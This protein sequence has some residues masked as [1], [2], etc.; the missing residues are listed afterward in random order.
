MISL[1][2][3][4]LEKHILGDSDYAKRARDEIKKLNEPHAKKLIRCVLITGE[5]GAGKNHLARVLAAH[6]RLIE[7]QSFYKALEIPTLEALNIETFDE[8]NL[9]SLSDDLIQSELFGHKARSFSGADGKK[10][11]IGLLSS[12]KSPSFSDILL[13]EIG[14]ASPEF[15]ANLLQVIDTGCFRPVG[16]EP[17]DSESTTA[18]FIFATN[19]NLEEKVREGT[20]REDLFHRL[21]EVQI[22]VPPLRSYASHI[23]ELLCTLLSEQIKDLGMHYPSEA[24]TELTSEELSW[25]KEFQWPGNIR[26]LRT[27]VKRW[28]FEAGKKQLFDLIE[29]PLEKKSHK[30]LEDDFH[31]KDFKSIDK[32]LKHYSTLAMK[33]LGEWV[34]EYEID[35]NKLQ[36]MFSRATLKNIKNK[37]NVYKKKP[38]DQS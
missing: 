37:I 25:A 29:V 26:A 19:H 17:G 11:K 31:E 22:E 24:R 3:Q 34:E 38:E 16:A 10:D 35:A 33:E 8:I 4:F 30:V 6:S 7:N 27:A 13:D 1:S 23:P 36:Q 15:Q 18:R 28:L 21:N 20:F 5:S 9:P 12:K 14:D 2:D 32:F